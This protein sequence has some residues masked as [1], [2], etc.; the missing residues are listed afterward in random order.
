MT[1]WLARTEAAARPTPYPTVA[2][3]SRV[4]T[5]PSRKAPRFIND[6]EQPQSSS[7]MS[8]YFDWWPTLGCPSPSPARCSS[9]EWVEMTFAKPA[10]VSET[11]V[12]W[13]DD[14][15]QG[16]VRVPASW[17]L[18]YKDGDQWKAVNAAGPYGIAKDLWNRVSF[19][20]VTTTALRIE[21]AMQPGVS[22]GLQEWRVTG[23]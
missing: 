7:D 17:R 4:T 15:G 18:L 6:G 20:P 9:G 1:V 10:T 2:T 3:T 11:A 21:L 8:A 12:Y 19:S 5:S 13:F 16:A 14:T 22:A 23:R